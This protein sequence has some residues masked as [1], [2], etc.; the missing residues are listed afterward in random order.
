[1]TA[2][3]ASVTRAHVGASGFSYPS[4]RPGFYPA[5]ARPED[6]LRLYAER[7]PSV[8]LNV[9]GYRLPSEEQ[10]ARWEAQ[11]PDTFTFS[12]K[13]PARA[14]RSVATFEERARRLGAKLGPIRVVV[15][16]PRDE[17]FLAL[18]LGSMD[19]EL[20]YA[21][22]LRDESWEGVDVSP[23]VRVGDLGEDTPFHY[24]RFR[25]PPYDDEAL[26]EA[27]AELRAPLAAGKDVFAYFRHEDEPT[28]PLYALRLLE[29]LA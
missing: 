23:A 4:W 13:M 8:E 29:L 16:Q 24:V 25:D 14:L 3:P 19:P 6:F 2:T 9:T 10:F 7:M 26:R 15:E 21:V 11:V 12:V 17:G 1:M 5:D 20:R 27:A 22:D 18:F 28:A